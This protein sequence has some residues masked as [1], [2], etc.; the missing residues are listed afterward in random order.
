MA[1]AVSGLTTHSEARC[2]GGLQGFYS[3]DSEACQGSMRFAVFQPPQALQG[4]KVPVLTYLSGLTCTEENFVVKAGAQRLA[5]ELGLMI[6]APDTSPRGAGVAGEDDDYDLGTGAGFYVD[7]TEAPWSRCYN[8]YSYVTRD[9]QAAIAG[10]FPADMSAQGLTGHSMGGHG[11][12][13]IG[14]KHP[15]TYRSLS[16][17]APICA[18]LQCPWGEKALGTYLG[19]DRESW[20]AYDSCE[21]LKTTTSEAKLLV[22]QGAD[23]GFLTEQLKPELL[24]QACRERGHA[25]ELRMQPG[26]DHSYYFIQTFMGDHL[27]HHAGALKG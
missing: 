8:M 11:A 5:A 4:Q 3:H 19:A 15:E 13:T 6:V 26:Y 21:L 2:F 23:D 14:L 25:L 27:H 1:Q 12:L 7:A 22:D 17:F 18:P 20:R 10:N 16:A 24:E 9:L